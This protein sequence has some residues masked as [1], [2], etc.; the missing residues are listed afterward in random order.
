[1][2]R[3]RGR[4][5]PA[6]AALF[7]CEVTDR[8]QHVVQLILPSGLAKLGAELQVFFDL[9]QRHGIDQVPKLLLAEELAQEVAI[10]R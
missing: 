1:M 5:A 4:R 2:R 8:P 6:P 3:R 10:E 7:G 9:R